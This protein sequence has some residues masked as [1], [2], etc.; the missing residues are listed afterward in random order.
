[1][2]SLAFLRCL[3]DR[4]VDL[5]VVVLTST[6]NREI[7]EQALKAGAVEV[8]QKPLVADRLLELMRALATDTG[9]FVTHPIRE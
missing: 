7:A 3:K 4:K 2:G 8:I 1:M 9:R 6:S 5:P